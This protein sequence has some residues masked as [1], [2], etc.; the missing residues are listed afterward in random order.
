MSP[1][2][3]KQIVTDLCNG[4]RD[5][6]LARIEGCDIPEEWDGIELRQLLAEM[7]WNERTFR[8]DRQFRHQHRFHPTCKRYLEYRNLVLVENLDR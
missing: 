7:F 8:F 4:V 6:L 2:Q 3:Q 1:E 5:K